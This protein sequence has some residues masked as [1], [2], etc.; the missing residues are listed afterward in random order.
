MSQKVT[1]PLPD[2]RRAWCGAESAT[3]ARIREHA[4]DFQVREILDYEFSGDGEHD[5]LLL[6]KTGANTAWAAEQLAAHAG[7]E[8][9]NVGF[10]GMKDR[11][12]I[13]RQWFSVQR[14]AAVADWSQFSVPGLRVIECARNRRKL[15]RGAH[16]GNRFRIAM[17]GA[18][19]ESATVSD[20]LLGIRSRGVPNYFGEQRFG[21]AA[22][23]IELA[24]QLFRGR[25]L[26]RQKRSLALSAA[27]A[28][29]FNH[30][31]ASRVENGSWDRLLP[32]D[33]A[34][35]DGSGSFFPVEEPDAALEERVRS[36][37]LHPS[38]AMWGK[39]QYACG[40]EV[41]A[42][43]RSMAER[44]DELSAGL[45]KFTDQSRRSLRLAVRQFEWAWDMDTLW[46]EFTLTRGGYATAVLREIADYADA[47][48]A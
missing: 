19:K 32:G 23:N 28:W 37:G 18:G 43:E 44:F 14:T 8:P 11:H 38:G 22:G 10:A 6:E 33:C 21:R 29:I 27:R 9:R 1:Q 34:S 25:R 3:A 42:L 7:I 12:S 40:G 26:S 17:R 20:R 39:G 47:A 30:I 45:E 13:S 2:W 36:L 35:L 15:R 16:S 41:A 48:A 24:R 31:L 46:L 5:Y 4:A